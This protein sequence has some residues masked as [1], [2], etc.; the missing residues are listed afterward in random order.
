MV[1]YLL[2]TYV[3]EVVITEVETE[4]ANFKKYAGMNTVWYSEALC[5]TAPTC[6]SVYN[7]PRLK[8][9]FIE[10][11]HTSILYSKRTYLREHKGTILHNL[12]RH[13]TLLVKLL[14]GTSIPTS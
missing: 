5:E 7:K 11:I 3:T 4:I 1:S 10:G 14:E 9:I 8:I 2:E 12:A 13:A 6:R